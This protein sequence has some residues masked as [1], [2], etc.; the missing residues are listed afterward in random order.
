MVYIGGT[1]QELIQII[2]HALRLGGFD[3]TISEIP[4]P[5]GIKP[6][7]ICNRCKTRKGVQ[8][9]L[10]RGLRETLFDNLGDRSLRRK[11]IVFYRF[12][13]ILKEALLLFLRKI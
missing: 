6:E 11:T 1:N 9:E 4:G 7:N 5:R 2:V 12:V 8:L 3:A 10:L 13:N